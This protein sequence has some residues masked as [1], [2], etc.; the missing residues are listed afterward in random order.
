MGIYATRWQQQRL[1]LH[2]DP[3]DVFN[4]FVVIFCE[5]FVNFP[6]G[7]TGGGPCILLASQ[8]PLAAL[9]MMFLTRQLLLASLLLRA[10]SQL[11][12]SSLL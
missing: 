1:L 11:L 6:I 12:A 4:G 5:I 10:I 7:N 9:M 8:V 3:D 2:A